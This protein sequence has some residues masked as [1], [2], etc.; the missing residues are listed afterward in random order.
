MIGRLPG[1]QFYSNLLS[2][3]ASGDYLKSGKLVA[4]PG[5]ESTPLVP[6]FGQRVSNGFASPLVI[7]PT[8]R[9]IHRS[10][11]VDPDG[12]ALVLYSCAPA[13]WPYVLSILN[14]CFFLW[15]RSLLS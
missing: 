10:D 9:N 12:P 14:E 13:S 2:C 15:P 1:A 4:C 8:L 5:F 11:A 3:R 7:V 6:I